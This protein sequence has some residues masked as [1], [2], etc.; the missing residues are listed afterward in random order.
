MRKTVPTSTVSVCRA[1]SS[2]LNCCAAAS[3]VGY[4]CASATTSGCAKAK[5]SAV[6][7][8]VARAETWPP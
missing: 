6:L 3:W 5:S 1:V 2:G 8:F 7:Y 4:L